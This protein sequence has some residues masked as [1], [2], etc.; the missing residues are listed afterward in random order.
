MAKKSNNA[1][2]AQPAPS[3]PTIALDRVGGIAIDTNIYRKAGFKFRTQPLAALA[4]IKGLQIAHLVP[5]IWRRELEAHAKDWAE[6]RLHETRHALQIGDWALSAQAS[7]ATDLRAHLQA[8]SGESI[9]SR[10]IDAHY[11]ASGAVQLATAWKA[12]PRVLSDYFEGRYPFERTGDKK[13]E[14]PDAFAL[15]TLEAWGEKMVK[16]VIVVTEDEGCLWACDASKYL[17]GFRS[18]TDAL[19]ALN[20]G[21]QTRKI[22]AA[23]LELFLVKELKS[24]VS[25]LRKDLDA[26]IGAEIERMDIE[27]DADS[28]V[29]HFDYDVDTVNLLSVIPAS[30]LRPPDLQVLSVGQH[31]LTFSWLFQVEVEVSARFYRIVGRNLPQT[32]RYG[33]PVDTRVITID[34]EAVITLQTPDVMSAVALKHALVK[35]FDFATSSLWLY[36]GD[37][38]PWEPDY[39]E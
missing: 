5:E 22:A 9:A 21:D 25:S 28:E 38:D 16:Q 23:E 27:L 8:D 19:R 36:F 2:Q 13:S 12:G 31:D 18:L 4:G 35:S 6:A 17:L 32:H 30:T 39:E 11:A 37:V 34:V 3:A 7:T 33:A 10:L 29:P 20:E 1:Q 14:F 15:A 26:L 24:E